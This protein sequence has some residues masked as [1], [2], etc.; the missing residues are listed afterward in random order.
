MMLE[1]K[2]NQARQAI[3]KGLDDAGNPFILFDGRVESLIVLHLL[4]QVNEGKI[5]IP[6]LYIDTTVDFKE[7][8]Q[9]IEKMR[10]LWGLKLIKETNQEALRTIK[11]AED[12]E[13]C[14]RMLKKNVLENI[15][16]KYNID[17]LFA[18]DD[19]KVK[20]STDLFTIN[21]RN[22]II[23]PIQHFYKEDVWNYIKKYNLSYCS[24]YD[25]GFKNIRCI[26]CTDPVEPKDE[27][28][29]KLEE[30][31][32]KKRLKALGYMQ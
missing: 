20:T 4:R 24:L 21:N 7:I 5:R 1:E 12:K 32:I 18:F 22:I 14:C 10:K 27:R 3:K 9:Y 17:R 11:F 31:E 26:P 6:V 8:Y 23:Y 28:L 2:E 13:K 19:E 30:D 29:E 16:K 15:I 25:K